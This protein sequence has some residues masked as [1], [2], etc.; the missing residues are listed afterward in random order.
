VKPTTNSG[1]RSWMATDR[2]FCMKSLMVR[3]M[4]EIHAALEHARIFWPGTPLIACRRQLGGIS[5]SETS[6]PRWATLKRFGFRA[7]ADKA[8]QLPAILREIEGHGVTGE[9]ETARDR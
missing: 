3:N 7:I 4:V 1:V 9:F 2:G 8:A 6:Q 5:R